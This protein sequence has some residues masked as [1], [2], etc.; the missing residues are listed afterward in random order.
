M[1]G[2]AGER[3]KDGRKGWREGRRMVGKVGGRGEGW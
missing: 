1:V 2:G 3:E